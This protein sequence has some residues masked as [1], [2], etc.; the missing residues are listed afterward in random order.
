[1]AA[2]AQNSLRLSRDDGEPVVEAIAGEPAATD[3]GPE[4]HEATEASGRDKPL[5]PA[6]PSLEA[7]RA[8]Q[9]LGAQPHGACYVSDTSL[10]D[11][12]AT[13]FSADAGEPPVADPLEWR[14][15]YAPAPLPRLPPF[16]W[17]A[18]GL[19]CAAADG[20]SAFERSFTTRH[21]DE[22]HAQ[23]AWHA[24][25]CAPYPV[26]LGRATKSTPPSACLA[27]PPRPTTAGKARPA[28]RAYGPLGDG[29]HEVYRHRSFG[30][31]LAHG[32]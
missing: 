25:A 18:G 7:R 5:L 31:H 14:S 30:S 3:M 11:G 32:T 26:M 12:V 29:R 22:L 24:G 4:E 17:V 19:E 13:F 2:R 20:A 21:I 28:W 27:P 10:D 9:P 23:R 15:P 1:M 8:R 6:W 16:E